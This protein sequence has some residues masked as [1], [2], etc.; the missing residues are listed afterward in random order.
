MLVSLVKGDDSA[1]D[2][3]CRERKWKRTAQRRA[4][5]TYLCGNRDHPAVETVWRGV[6][7]TLPD[8][9]LDSVYRILDDFAETGLIRKL[10][11]A[12][13]VRYDPD[14]SVHEHFICSACGK[15]FDFAFPDTGRAAELAGM[16]GTVDSVEL[17]AH[18]TCNTCLRGEVKQAL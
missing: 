10:E 18:G 7:E 4:V 17:M 1:F 6:R 13:V 9:S 11:G 3:L 12:K 2:S 14:T 15:M 5:F 16:F 8:V